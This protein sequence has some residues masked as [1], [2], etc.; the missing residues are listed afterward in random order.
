MTVDVK[1][2]GYDAI[3]DGR[4][5]MLPAV[6]VS[7]NDSARHIWSCMIDDDADDGLLLL[8]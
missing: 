5:A 8:L 1:G 3:S 7:Q 2:N 6:I 4:E